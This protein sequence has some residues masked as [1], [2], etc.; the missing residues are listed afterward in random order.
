MSRREYKE[1]EVETLPAGY[2]RLEYIQTN[3]NLM[4]Y[5]DTGIYGV[6]ES[7]RF[8]FDVE[9]YDR[10]YHCGLHGTLG[11]GGSERIATLI[12]MNS[13]LNGRIDYVCGGT[14]YKSSD[15]YAP[16]N[17]RHNII[18]SKDQIVVDGVS[19]AKQYRTYQID[20]YSLILMAFEYRD[21]DNTKTCS[22][23]KWFGIKVFDNEGNQRL[24]LVPALRLS[25]SKPGMYDSINSQFFTNSGSGEFSY[26]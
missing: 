10:N 19:H 8:E 21:G 23:G 17:Q 12:V 5:I 1:K 11:R 13:T 26:A 7:W 22:S 16:A 15:A 2:Q 14:G 25:D 4:Q 9:P 18:V 3:Y 6:T 24:D 20:D